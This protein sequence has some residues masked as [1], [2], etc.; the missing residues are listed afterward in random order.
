MYL[1]LSSDK[2][3]K[4]IYSEIVLVNTPEQKETDMNAQNIN[5]PP[6][7]SV[8]EAQKMLGGRGRGKIYAL[9]ASSE[10]D[11]VKDGNR[12]LILT[13]SLLAYVES[14][15]ISSGGDTDASI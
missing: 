8:T 9:L 13:A 14:L 2:L 4:S 7:I 15:K 12:R 6:L 11:S 1:S 5:Y 3:I 10:L